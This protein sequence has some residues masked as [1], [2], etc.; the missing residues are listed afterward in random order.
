MLE[1]LVEHH[2][3]LDIS[4]T[5]KTNTILL[6]KDDEWEFIFDLYLV[7]KDLSDVTTYMTNELNVSVSQIYPIVSRLSK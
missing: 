6:P 1:H 3:M 4:I 2:L 5:K 7:L